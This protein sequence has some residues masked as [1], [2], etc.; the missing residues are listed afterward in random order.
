[1]RLLLPLFVVVIILLGLTGTRPSSAQPQG[2]SRLYLPV[3]GRAGAASLVLELESDSFGPQL[4]SALALGDTLIYQIYKLDCG[5]L[6]ATGPAPNTAVRLVPPRP[7]L[8]C[9]RI[10]EL[11]P[12]GAH[13]YF[14]VEDPATND[15]PTL[16]RT[17]GTIVGTTALHVA[18]AAPTDRVVIDTRSIE[19]FGQKLYFMVEK[20][21]A[22]APW[23]QFELWR[24]DGTP[25]GMTR[26]KTFGDIHTLQSGLEVLGD[27]LYFALRNPQGDVVL[28]ASD[29][30]EAGTQPV[31]T[32]P[33]P[34]YELTVS[35]GRLWLA[36]NDPLG[37]STLWVSDGTAAGTRPVRG[38]DGLG[39]PGRFAG[40]EGRLYFSLI[41][42]F[43]GG[44]SFNNLWTSDGTAAGTVQVAE[45]SSYDNPRVMGGRLYFT[46]EGNLYRS[47]GTTAGTFSIGRSFAGPLT[48]A[49]ER[50]FFGGGPDYPTEL[51]V[52]D[53]TAA[54]TRPALG[55]GAGV[56]LSNPRTIV[57]GASIVYVTATD[58]TGQGGLWALP[59]AQ[60]P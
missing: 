4:S 41:I 21:S 28:W 38:F 54:G 12:V 44:F 34:L 14:T 57:A 10:G 26:V 51:W 36:T 5:E 37:T 52:S 25:T 24:S 58:Q 45:A 40:L 48:V 55:P 31:I 29:G 13:A 35:S 50:L 11:V 30:T 23:G 47:D 33:G 42:P 60:V 32:L 2:P 22:G 19:S 43:V 3:V 39:I 49:G 1:M 16:W 8:E 56:A 17:D 53:G 15:A 9:E 46:A 7:G 20:R 27:R 18:T 59:F 6:W